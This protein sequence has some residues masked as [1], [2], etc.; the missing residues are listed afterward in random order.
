MKNNLTQE[1][2]EDLELIREKPAILKH[3]TAEEQFEE[4]CLEAVKQSGIVLR[5]V[6]KQ[7]PKIC[8]EAVKRYGDAL[9]IEDGKITIEDETDI[10]IVLKAL[11]DYYKI[12]EISGK[13]YGTFSGKELRT[14]E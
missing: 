5:Y 8:L 2:L 13:P 4:L 12:G 10:D 6:K 9:K 7:T 11:G 1:Q 3:Y 14:Q